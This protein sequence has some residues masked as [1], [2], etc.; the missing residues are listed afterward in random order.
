MIW[1]QVLRHRGTV[2]LY[3]PLIRPCLQ[4][5]AK[6][7]PAPHSTPQGHKGQNDLTHHATMNYH[8][9]VSHSPT[10]KEQAGKVLTRRMPRVSRQLLF[11]TRNMYH[12]TTISGSP[13]CE[14]MKCDLG[15][16]GPLL[17]VHFSHLDHS[18]RVPFES[19][20]TLPFRHPVLQIPY[21]DRKD[22]H[23]V[24]FA[25][26]RTLYICAMHSSKINLLNTPLSQRQQVSIP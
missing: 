23:V 9:G 20:P 1:R 25:I 18:S 22:L 10:S 15:V 19:G 4:Q 3:C 5:R 7:R 6:L 17:P 16:A 11:G 13:A 2:I 8:D 24:L 26:G 14:Q 21:Q 12:S